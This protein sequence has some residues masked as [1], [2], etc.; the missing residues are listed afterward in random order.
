MIL[1]RL[2]S[3]LRPGPKEQFL[4]AFLI[5]FLN[6]HIVGYSFGVG[7][8]IEQLPIVKALI[9]TEDRETNY[10][11]REVMHIPEIILDKFGF[12]K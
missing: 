6:V 1:Q 11:T 3:E 9:Y 12:K 4:L 5:T 2:Q 10:A 7:D 8:Q